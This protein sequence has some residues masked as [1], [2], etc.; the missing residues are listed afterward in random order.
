MTNGC[1]NFLLLLLQMYFIDICHLSIHVCRWDTDEN[2]VVSFQDSS[3]LPYLFSFLKFMMSIIDMRH[4][5]TNGGPYPTPGSAAPLCIGPKNQRHWIF[6]G[7]T[8]WIIHNL[9]K[10]DWYVWLSE[11][12]GEGVNFGDNVF[13]SSVTTEKNASRSFTKTS[14]WDVRW[15][16][17]NRP[18]N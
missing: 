1:V 13:Q 14:F 11:R 10:Y 8:F 9:V 16:K 6:N 15:W 18:F 3:C 7:I 17:V 4:L 2:Y 5:W 12:F